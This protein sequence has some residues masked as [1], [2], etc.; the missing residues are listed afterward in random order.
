MADLINWDTPEVKVWPEEMT[1]E[2][3]LSL[4]QQTGQYEMWEAPTETI[5][6]EPIPKE[7]PNAHKK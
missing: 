1:D 5:Y 7:C 3:I 4:A 2:E 6:D